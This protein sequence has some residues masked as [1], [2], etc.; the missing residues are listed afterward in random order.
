MALATALSDV[1][2][3][4]IGA[5]VCG[6]IAIWALNTR[7]GWTHKLLLVSDVRCENS[8]ATRCTGKNATQMCTEQLDQICRVAFQG[9][10]K[11]LTMR[12]RVG[13]SVPQVDDLMDV[14]YDPKDIVNTI[15]TTSFPKDIIVMLFGLSC[16]AQIA[17]IAWHVHTRRGTP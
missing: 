12:I 14:Y 13:F 4:V 11:E 16:L 6:L 8:N 3:L 5:I 1:M 17:Y 9:L 10:E 15:T 2:H 7:A